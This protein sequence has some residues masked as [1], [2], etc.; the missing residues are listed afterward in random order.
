MHELRFISDEA[1]KEAQS[2]PLVV[3]QGIRDTLPT[4][5]ESVAEMARQ[6]VFDAY[7][8]EAY[9]RGITVW[10][11]VRK[12]DQEAAYAAVRRGVLEYDRRHG[13]RGPEAFVNLPADAA[14]QDAGPR[15]GL[16]GDARRRQP[17][18]GGGAGRHRQRGARRSSPSGDAVVLKGDAIKFVARNLTDKTPAAQRIRRGA[19]DPPVARTTRTTGRS[20]RCRR[21]RRRSS[22]SRR[23]TGRSSR[24]PAASSTSATSSTT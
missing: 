10:T 15:Q 1:L 21:P 24:S 14:E 16:P 22:P 2:A 19:V 7:G 4:H 8:D 9:T 18:G 11:T 3:R 17:R 13:Y 20:R 6:V 12:A 5:G 23:S